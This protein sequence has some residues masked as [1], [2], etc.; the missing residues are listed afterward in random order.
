[1]PCNQAASP[2]CH[3]SMCSLQQLYVDVRGNTAVTA[4]GLYLLGCVV[5][6]R[7]L[8]ELHFDVSGHLSQ[9]DVRSIT[10]ALTKASCAPHL[11]VYL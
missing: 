5:T 3:W 2:V 4:D 10:I 11:Q 6:L 9:G 1:M 7:A 8:K